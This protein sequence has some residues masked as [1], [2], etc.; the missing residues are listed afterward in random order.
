MTSFIYCF[1]YFVGKYGKDKVKFYSISLFYF[2]AIKKDSSSK[3]QIYFK[4]IF[5]IGFFYFFSFL[6]EAGKDYFCDDLSM[7]N[8]SNT[9]EIDLIL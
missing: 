2:K 8:S 5:W 7:E 9:T 4:P 3:S 6:G 1:S